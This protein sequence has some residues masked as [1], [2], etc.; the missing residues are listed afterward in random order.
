MVSRQL[1]VTFRITS[2]T[3]PFMHASFRIALVIKYFLHGLKRFLRNSEEKMNENI[4][5]KNSLRVISSSEQKR[6]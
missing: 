6:L 1:Q 3:V 4:I 2:A 5:K